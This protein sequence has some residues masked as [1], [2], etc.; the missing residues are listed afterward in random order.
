MLA[1]ALLLMAL[2]LCAQVPSLDLVSPSDLRHGGTSTITLSGKNLQ[3]IQS[4]WIGRTLAAKPVDGAEPGRQRLEVTV[5]EDVAPGIHPLRIATAGGVS[6]PWLVVIDDLRIVGSGATNTSAAAAQTLAW[7]C[8]VHGTVDSLKSRH[9]KFAGK[10]GERVSIEVVA[11]RI[12]SS[13]DPVVR[14]F[15]SKDRE[16]AYSDDEPGLSRD[17]RLAIVL[18]SDDTYRIELRD[19]LN[20]GGSKHRFLLRLGDFPELSVPFPMVIT[21]K[22]ETEIQPLAKGSPSLPPI[23]ITPQTGVQAVPFAVRSGD[24]K[25]SA[26]GLVGVAAVADAVESE[27]NDIPEKANRITV[28]GIVEGRFA[29]AR[30]RD[31]FE[32]EVKK[33][34][35]LVF[36]TQTRE[37]ASPSDVVMD[38]RDTKG[39]RIVPPKQEEDEISGILTNT[40]NEAGI[41]RIQIRDMVGRGEPKEAYRLLIEPFQQVILRPDKAVLNVAAGDSISLVVKADRRGYTGP[42]QLELS[43]L[44]DGVQLSENVI[45]EK[46]DETTLKLSIPSG[47]VIGQLSRLQL[48]GKSGTPDSSV[49]I[50]TSSRELLKKSFPEMSVPPR[51]LD[52]EILLNVLPAKTGK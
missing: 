44:P 32:F 36:S 30:D 3:N 24:G 29:Q 38:F 41:C 4:V 12:N 22:V 47:A 20:E 1:G 6:N 17:S 43:G 25:G 16:L 31:W 35:R 50:K 37:V 33:G 14:L 49:A 26:F 46:K 5:P 7:P 10:K 39:N 40:F 9:F 45:A 13:L 52:G 11:Q 48:V 15:D 42:I 2:P 34:Q 27:P 19:I 18:P 23:R 28:P 8:A 21:G 51:A